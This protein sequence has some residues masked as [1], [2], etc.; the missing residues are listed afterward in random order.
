VF[1]GEL[2]DKGAD[3]ILFSHHQSNWRPIF[4][5]VVKQ[6]T[7]SLVLVIPLA[8]LCALSWAY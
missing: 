6:R 8:C 1:N 3:V 7:S 4:S 2:F 5:A